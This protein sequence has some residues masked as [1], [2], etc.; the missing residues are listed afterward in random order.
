MRSLRL[1]SSLT[2]RLALSRAGSLV[3]ASALALGFVFI[4]QLL[5]TDSH[6]HTIDEFLVVGALC[7]LAI[8][9]ELTRR[10]DIKEQRLA[11]SADARL[12]KSQYEMALNNT[13]QGLVMLGPDERIVV[14]NDAYINMYGLS[15]DI[16]KPGCTLLEAL[17]HRHE[18]G[19]LSRSPEIVQ[20][21]TLAMI[22][23]GT[24]SSW[25]NKMPD[26]RSVQISN[27]PMAGGGW[28]STHQDVT[29]KLRFETALNNMHQGLVM[30]D[31]DERIVVCNDAYMKMYNFSPDLMKPGCTLLEAIRYRIDLGLYVGDAE[32]YRRRTIAKIMAEEKSSWI[33]ETGDGRSIQVSV[34]HMPGGGWVSTHEDVTEK[35]RYEKALADSRALALAAERAAKEAHDRMKEAF[36]VVPEALALFDAQDRFVLWNKRYSD[37]Y[38]GSSIQVGRKFEDF[39]REMLEKGHYPDAVGREEEW[40]QERLAQHSLPQNRH[41]HRVADRWIRVDERRTADGGSIGIRVDITELKNRES[42]LR[43]LYESN[44]LPM[45]LYDL[46]TK[47]IVSANDSMVWHYGYAR[48]KLLTMN[49]RDLRTPAN[50]DLPFQEFTETNGVLNATQ[51]SRHRKADG[52]DINIMYYVRQLPLDGRIVG[53]VAVVDITDRQKAAEELNSTREFLN[54]VL[55]AVP[56]AIMVRNAVDSRYTL[57]NKAC[58]EFFGMPREKVIG[59]TPAELF[60]KPVADSISLHDDKLLAQGGMTIS[61]D[62]R[63]AHGENSD[64]RVVNSRRLVVRGADN[65]PKFFLSVVEDVTEQKRAKERIAYLAHHD[66]LTG[67]ANRAAF[68]EKFPTMLEEAGQHGETLGVMC[69]D[70]DRF[71]EVNDLF[72][73][74]IGDE[75]LRQVSA[76]LREV[77]GKEILIARLGGDEF[78]ILM[79]GDATPAAL[80]ELSE[81]LI[82]SIAEPFD[83]DGK[84]IRVGLTVGVAVFPTDGTEG[85]ALLGNADAALYRAKAEGRGSVRFFDSEMDRH[86]KRR[87]A[88][89]F[90]LQQALERG[91]F[92][93]H[94]QPQATISGDIIGFEALIRWANPER[95]NVPPATFIPVAEETGLIIPI[96]EWVLREACREAA[97][98]P[99]PLQ[100]ALN[101]SPAQFLRGNLPELV[102]SVLVETGLAANRL[103]LEITEGVLIGDFARAK[104]I[105]GRLKALGV[106]IAMDDFGTGYSSL[107]YLQSF[108][109]DKIKIDRAFISNVDGNAQSAAIVRAAIGLGHGL[110]LPVIA[111]GVE[112][113]G[114]LDFLS[115]ESCDEIQGYFIGKPQPISAYQA[116]ISGETSSTI[117]NVAP[118]EHAPSDAVASVKRRKLA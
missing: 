106:R 96:G 39:S 52:T 36:D 64:P 54:A 68:E 103:E 60:A 34:A 113:E 114:Q 43:L 20:A 38:G 98:W 48:D 30:V 118:Q 55:E 94:Y 109:F 81:R 26:G 18:L 72:G 16:I 73:H 102:L 90:E 59:R 107:S 61:F 50:R 31:R 110:N 85:S 35:L 28:V 105:L 112:T 44:P 100:I 5:T 79:R 63:P 27:I 42:S 24:D 70:L 95:G 4:W 13:R 15:R 78:T 76:R 71:K 116:L 101:L 92:A 7:A 74:S 57:I 69:T 65:Q 22:A 51:P 23:R 32:E 67:L 9:A 77:A 11:S 91:E 37:L 75:L 56:S 8:V 1:W 53:L 80:Q 29:E 21:S 89:Q 40:L 58:E 45:Y 115:R 108:P 46:D 82:A 3:V 93:L 66:M 6:H 99:R 88:L 49:V 62:G 12:K 33:S 86:L 47:D 17:K 10:R 97:S 104:N 14:C 83:I 2:G 19:Q 25:I 117:N 84:S 111:E 41:E 87:R